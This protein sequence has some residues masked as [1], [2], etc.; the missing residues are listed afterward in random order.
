MTDQGVPTTLEPM[1]YRQAEERMQAKAKQIREVE[2]AYR[3]AY[4]DAANAEGIYRKALGERVK[5]L[6]N[7]GQSQ[8]SA[9]TIARGELFNLCVERDKAAGK[10]RYELERLDDR[11]GERASLHKLVEWSGGVDIMERRSNGRAPYANDD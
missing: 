2:A 10:V 3:R 6:R 9:N 1:T 7:E 11:R 5:A 4:E 8:E